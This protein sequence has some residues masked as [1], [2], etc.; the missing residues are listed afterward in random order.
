MLVVIVLIIIFACVGAYI[1]TF[2]DRVTAGVWLGLFFGPLGWIITLLLEDRRLKCPECR[3][4]I[5]SGAW[6]CKNCGVDFRDLNS[7]KQKK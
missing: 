6:R 4:L 2:R 5:E 7:P 3:G 1:G